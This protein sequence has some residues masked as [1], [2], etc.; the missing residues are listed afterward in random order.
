MTADFQKSVKQK[1]EIASKLLL[2][3][4]QQTCRC[5]LGL[6]MLMNIVPLGCLE[7]GKGW[8]QIRQW[9]LALCSLAPSF[10][11]RRSQVL[12]W[13]IGH[14]FKDQTNYIFHFTETGREWAMV[15][16][17]LVKNENTG[18]YGLQLFSQ[19]KFS[20][21]GERSNWRLLL[22]P[23]QRTAWCLL[24]LWNI[25]LSSSLSLSFHPAPS[26]LVSCALSQSFGAYWLHQNLRGVSI[27]RFPTLH[28]GSI[29]PCTKRLQAKFMSILQGHVYSPK[30]T[31]SA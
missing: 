6:G 2:K 31:E 10:S 14:K 21:R 5:W 3:R 18:G 11:Q 4:E 28:R 29:G 26:L 1:H 20:Q 7:I 27:P 25:R 12:P 8:V 17:W 23:I 30:R 9:S 16:P 24:T 15:F 19:V 13:Q 22:L